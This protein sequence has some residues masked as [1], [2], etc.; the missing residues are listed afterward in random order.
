MGFPL[1][2]MLKYVSLLVLIVLLT[3]ELGEGRENEEKGSKL[4]QKIK[5]NIEEVADKATKKGNGKTKNK[6]WG[7]KESN[8]KKKGNDKKKAS[9]SISSKEQELL[10]KIK[11]GKKKKYLK[12]LNK[13]KNKKEKSKIVKKM[14]KDISKEKAR[15]EGDGKKKASGSISSKKQNMLN[16][17]KLDKKQKYLKELNDAKN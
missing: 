6:T 4:Y 13:A 3:S 16:K 7:K 1:F 14:K 8:G 5:K 12:G 15:K 10:N 9:G 17:I 2:D 11:L